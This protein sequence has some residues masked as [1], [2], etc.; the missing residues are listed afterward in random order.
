MLFV[1]FAH[2]DAR[3]TGTVVAAPRTS[4]RIMIRSL[5]FL[6]ALAALGAAVVMPLRGSLPAI[7]GQVAASGPT[8]PV[9]IERD[10]LGVLTIIGRA[11]PTSPTRPAMCTR[12]I[13]TSRWTCRGACRP[14]DLRSSSAMRPCRPTGAIVCTGSSALAA[15]VSCRARRPASEQCSTPIRPVS[16]PVSHRLRVR[17]FEYLLLRQAPEPWRR[18]RQLDVVFAM[19]LQLNDSR[20]ETDRRRGVLTARLPPVTASVSCIRYR[21]SGR[22]PSMA[23]DRRGADAP[24]ADI[25]PARSMRVT[26]R[27]WRC[28][29]APARPSRSARS[30]AITGRVGGQ[31]HDEWQG[32]WSRT[33][34]ISG[35]VCRTPGIARACM[36]RAAPMAHGISIGLTLPGVADAGGRQ[37]SQG[38]LGFYQQLRRLE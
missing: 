31:P 17:P 1:R 6:L 38:G 16:T 19:Y 27:C 36:C 26:Q 20:A 32:H 3:A 2:A 23:G 28:R 13:V 18:T 4:M 35:S 34:C 37:Q 25:R 8:A 7:D 11:A 15:D 12:R 24:P 21:R 14:D 33:T 9:T 30:A 10:A 5:L 22:R 29:P